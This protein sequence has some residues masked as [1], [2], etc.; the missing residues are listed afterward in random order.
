MVKFVLF[1]RNI[2]RCSIIKMAFTK[3][4]LNPHR[5]NLQMRLTQLLKLQMNNKQFLVSFLF[6]D[7][8]IN[9]GFF[10]PYNI[11]FVN[12]IDFAY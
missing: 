9:T 11:F 4:V 2:N 12:Y 5:N 6:S 10:N 3:T 7:N 8:F 1:F